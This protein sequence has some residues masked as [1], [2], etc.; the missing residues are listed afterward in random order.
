MDDLSGV[1]PITAT[2]FDI[3]GRV[4]EDSIVSLVEFEAR[5]AAG[6]FP[7]VVGTSHAGIGACIELSQR[8]EAAGAAAMY[9]RYASYR[10]ILERTQ[11]IE[12][13]A[14]LDGRGPSPATARGERQP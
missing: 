2:P 9:D 14:H 12:P 13:E 6:R 8:A 3:G 1:T 7:I 11:L 10:A 4:D 5:C